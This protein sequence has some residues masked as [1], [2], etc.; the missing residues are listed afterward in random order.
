MGYEWAIH[1]STFLVL[2]AYRGHGAT[3][4]PAVSLLAAGLAG[5][6]LGLAVYSLFF[7]APTVTALLGLALLVGVVR[8]RGN[9]AKLLRIAQHAHLARRH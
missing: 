3:Y 6:S 1:F 7:P 2:A 4:R 8:C 9:V 5:L